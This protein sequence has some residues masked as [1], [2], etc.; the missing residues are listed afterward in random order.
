[1][2]LLRHEINS[3]NREKYIRASDIAMKALVPISKLFPDP[4]KFLIQHPNTK[5]LVEILKE[6]NEFDKNE[7]RKVVINAAV[8]LVI[9][10]IEHS[11]NWRDVF[12]WWIDRLRGGPWKQCSYNHPV[13]D[14]KEP[15]PYG[16]QIE[17]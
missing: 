8:R 15:K 17:W 9:D 14:W 2:I 7:R 1:M 6:Y 3:T 12:C 4:D 10:K 11:P 16:R 13:N 5:R